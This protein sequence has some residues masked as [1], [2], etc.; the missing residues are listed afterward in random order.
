MLSLMRLLSEYAR[1]KLSGGIGRFDI[2]H[3]EVSIYSM[4]GYRL[5][6]T[7]FSGNARH[8]RL[9]RKAFLCNMMSSELSL[10]C[11]KGIPCAS[12][13]LERIASDRAKQ[14]VSVAQTVS[15]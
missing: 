1:G 14:I 5:P 12:Q 7:T 13:V 3:S 15:G 4:L 6:V 2:S 11:L 10:D 9:L 8:S